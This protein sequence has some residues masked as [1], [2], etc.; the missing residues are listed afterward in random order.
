MGLGEKSDLDALRS[1]P[2]GRLPATWLIAQVGEDKAHHEF[3]ELVGYHLATAE[4]KPELAYKPRRRAARQA[5][6]MILLALAEAK[7]E[8]KNDQ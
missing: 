7:A 2:E 6:G 1:D 8:A 5:A 3:K 4:F